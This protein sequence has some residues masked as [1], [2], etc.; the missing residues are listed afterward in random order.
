MLEELGAV[1]GRVERE[2]LEVR[3]G[4][5]IREPR[6]RVKIRGF[7]SEPLQDLGQECGII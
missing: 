4:Q 7:Y 2:A 5:T 3:H 1:R 6:G